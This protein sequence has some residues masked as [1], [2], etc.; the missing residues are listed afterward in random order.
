MGATEAEDGVVRGGGG[1]RRSGRGRG[2]WEGEGE[3][4]RDWDALESREERTRVSRRLTRVC[5]C[6]RP[7]ESR[8][9]QEVARS[10]IGDSREAGYSSSS[11]RRA[12]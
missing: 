10:G 7:E 4:E 12:P 6:G 5:E 2:G 3:V 9:Y 8:G 1:G 11:L